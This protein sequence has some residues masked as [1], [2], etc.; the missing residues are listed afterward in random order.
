MKKQELNSRQWKLYNYL[1]EKYTEKRYIS[2]QEICRD[3]SNEYH[4]KE[5]ET[6]LCR[7][8]EEDVRRIN[9]AG[10]IQKIIISSS[11]GYK[12]GNEEECRKYIEKR[13]KRDLK[14][15]KLN[16]LLAN[17]VKMDGQMKIVF[18][19]ERDF[20]ETFIKE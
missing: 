17:K 6:R 13:F 9:N 7:L 8:I 20:I 12:I 10:V 15:L 2:K 16:W 4:I 11:K 19:T 5:K 14:S 3:L 18:N 1:K